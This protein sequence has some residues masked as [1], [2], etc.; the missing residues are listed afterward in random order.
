MKKKY[1]A[2]VAL[3]ICIASKLTAQNAKYLLQLQNKFI[4]FM[5]IKTKRDP[6]K[7]AIFYV[8]N[9]STKFHQNLSTLAKG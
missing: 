1:L 8:G 3:L 9:D 7:Y 4:T 5:T 2:P 6:V